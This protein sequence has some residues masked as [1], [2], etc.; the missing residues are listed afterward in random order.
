M[1]ASTKNRLIDAGL[2]TADSDIADEDEIWSHY[3]NDKVDIGER[4]ASVIRT[5][6]AAKPL[7]WKLRAL[8]LGSS[9]EPQFRILETAFRG[10]LY[11]FDI[12]QRALDILE[13]RIQ[14][15]YTDHVSTI[16]GD[17]TGIFLNREYCRN[18]LLEKLDNRKVDLITL[19]HSL[20]YCTEDSW[21]GLFE[22]LLRQFLAHE[23]AVHAVLMANSSNDERTTTWL[24]N[25]F[26][27]KFFGVR[28]N[29]SLPAL[30]KEL[31]QSRM[32][33][34]SQ[35]MISTS[36]VKFFVNDFAKFMKVIWMI[37]LHPNVH[38]YNDTQKEEI[39]SFIIDNLWSQ[40]QPLLQKQHHLVIYRGMDFK[41][42]I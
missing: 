34:N 28:N 3:S 10:G 32:F 40:R 19:H 37:L 9:S 27:G 1:D 23:G 22:E 11:L 39:I 4:L 16:R 30:K 20:Y 17:Y 24:Y 29:Q 2:R 35:I 36:N 8:S 6:H 5:L 25:H 14:R 26:A 7:T 12:D 33:S 38:R 13:E 21:C 18:F 42:I 41:G 15:Q 31:E